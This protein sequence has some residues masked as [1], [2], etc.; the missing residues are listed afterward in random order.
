MKCWKGRTDA[1]PKLVILFDIDGTLLSTKVTQQDE[2]RRYLQAIRDVTG[3]EPKVVP[4]RFAGMV[5]PQ[6][7]TILLTELG[8]NQ[9]SVD[10]LVPKVVARMGLLYHDMKKRKALNE[11]VEELLRTLSKSP[12][13]I[14]GV[15]TGNIS[16]IG[17]EKLKMT[18]IS[19]YFTEKFYADEY[20]DRNRLVEDAVA[21][22][23]TKY[24]LS[25][26]RNVMIV[27][28]TPLDMAAASAA[29][30]TSIGIASG[31]FS[32]TQL[33]DAGAK[34]AF[35]NLRPSKELLGAL[36]VVSK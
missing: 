12:N 34:W 5:D 23:V 17:E 24:H 15:L 18:S 31:V 7:C 32:I 30:A 11:G 25:D 1:L 33:L 9:G 16:A 13:H 27:G 36:G 20:Y 8:L 28:D 10:E 6:I 4:S 29:N 26:R 21:S 3:K 22:C 19:S 35:P 2:G 14:L